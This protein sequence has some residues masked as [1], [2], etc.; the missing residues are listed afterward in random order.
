MLAGRADETSGLFLEL[1]PRNCNLMMKVAISTLP[2]FIAWSL[3][4]FQD[5]LLPVGLA[6]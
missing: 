3:L 5:Q 4:P 6:M 1:R 2:L